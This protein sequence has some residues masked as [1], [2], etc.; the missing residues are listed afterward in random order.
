MT[1]RPAATSVMSSV[2]RRFMVLL[3]LAGLARAKKN[4]GRK[5]RDGVVSA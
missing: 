4:P 1:A 3:C 5:A 2:E